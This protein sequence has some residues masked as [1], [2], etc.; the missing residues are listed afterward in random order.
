[1]KTTIEIPDHLLRRA[2]A[3]A[4]LSGETLKHFVTTAIQEH[5][6]RNGTA[7]PESRGWRA[8]FGLAPRDEVEEIDDIISAELEQ[9]DPAEWR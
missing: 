2:K 1:M 9:V 6:Q 8:V 7:S 3:T 4:A 5:L